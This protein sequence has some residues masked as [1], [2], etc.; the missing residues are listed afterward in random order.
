MSIVF[1][2]QILV[3]HTIGQY[4]TEWKKVISWLIQQKA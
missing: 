1:S 2:R 3:Y 4:I